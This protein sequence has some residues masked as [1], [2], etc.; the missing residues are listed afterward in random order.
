MLKV[1]VC[2]WVVSHLKACLQHWYKH[3]LH[4]KV[5]VI[6]VHVIV[7][8]KDQYS[9]RYTCTLYSD[10][11]MHR[12][13]AVLGH[14]WVPIPSLQDS[15][16]NQ[17][18]EKSKTKQS[19]LFKN[20]HSLKYFWKSELQKRIEKSCF[21]IQ[22]GQIACAIVKFTSSYSNT[23]EP[24]HPYNFPYH[25]SSKHE[26]VFSQSGYNLALGFLWE[27]STLHVPQ[28]TKVHNCTLVKVFLLYFAVYSTSVCMYSTRV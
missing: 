26:I 11:G 7:N 14:Q 15:S 4:K 1:G 17:N 10:C 19:E 12:N 21:K 5:H 27:S 28:V 9:T 18:R 20:A 8:N 16:R 13:V 23:L 2:Y 22:M 3:V 25:F 24:I 6:M